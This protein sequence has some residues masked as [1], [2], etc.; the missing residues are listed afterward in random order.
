MSV[1][2]IIVYERVMTLSTKITRFK[3][4]VGI[5]N[6]GTV[7]ERKKYEWLN[8]SEKNKLEQN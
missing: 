2:V 7:R 8:E 5:I 6:R 3:K 4:S 1:R